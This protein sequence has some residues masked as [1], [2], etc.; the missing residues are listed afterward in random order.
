MERRTTK[1]ILWLS[2]LLVLLAGM[3][4]AATAKAGE[5]NIYVE[6]KLLRFDGQQP[7]IRDGTTLV[8]FRKTFET[9]GYKVGWDAEEKRASGTKAGMEIELTMGSPSAKVNGQ[10]YK[11]AVPAQ[12]MN[13]STMIPLRFV[14]ESSGYYVSYNQASGTST[15]QITKE[16]KVLEPYVVKGTVANAQGVPIKGA[17]I[18]IDNQ[19][20]YDSNLQARTD[21]NGR[22]RINLPK[23]ATTYV[24]YADFTTVYDGEEHSFEL[25]PD[26]P[27]PFAGNTGAI[28]NFTVK[29]SSSTGT[30]GVGEVL[31]YMMDLIHPLDPIAEPP[32][33][34][35]V[36]LTLEPLGVMMDGTVGGPDIVGKGS[37]NNNG[38]GIHDV[39]I[40]EYRVSAVYA[41]PGEEPQQMLIRIVTNGQDLPYSN[42]IEAGFRRITSKIHM[43]EL[44][45]KLDV[46]KP[47]DEEPGEWSW[48][49][50]DEE[51][52]EWTW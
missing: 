46:V 48:G 40:G 27:G 9:L 52:D 24:A 3:A 44:E 21:S 25:T 41:P 38:Y 8:P 23:A 26:D 19:L 13:G 6:G 45:L 49:D 14:S 2:C 51:E 12:I 47:P 22:Y 11:L 16:D 15:I 34:D 29:L 5:I 18:T 30:G 37:V 7:V 4:G 28:R 36:T 31:F 10:F 42:A 43:M 17:L 1:V 50:E 32:N 35:H 33:R 20:L 39:P